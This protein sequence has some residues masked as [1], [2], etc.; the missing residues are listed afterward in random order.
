LTKKPLNAKSGILLSF[1]DL[2]MM[3]Q[4]ASYTQ[5]WAAANMRAKRP[6]FKK[7]FS[8]KYLKIFDFF[9]HCFGQKILQVPFFIPIIGLNI[10]SM[11]WKSI[12]PKKFQGLFI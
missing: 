3:F 1:F 5:Q 2:P 10:I 9:G 7:V 8:L 12:R 4:V 6:F 11:F